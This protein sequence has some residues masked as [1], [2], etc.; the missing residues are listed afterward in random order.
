MRAL[1]FLSMVL[2]GSCLTFAGCETEPVTST[3]G[4]TSS[5]RMTDADLERSVRAKLDSEPSLQKA[6]LTVAAHAASNEVSLSG[7][8]DSQ[9]LKTRAVQLAKGAKDGLIVTDNI[10]VKTGESGSL[11]DYTTEKARAARDAAARLGE[12]VGDSLQDAWIHTKIVSKLVA[13]SDTP[14]RKINVDVVG[15]VVT[16]RGSVDS[17]QQKAEAERLAR[18]TDGVTKINNLIKVVAKPAKR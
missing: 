2:L 16:L 9:D 12:Q 10:T 1:L 14:E 18:E 7:T 17:P 3:G 15:T 13:N 4:G 6:N 5:S 8:V 11:T